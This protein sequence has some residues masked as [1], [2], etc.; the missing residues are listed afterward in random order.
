MFQDITNSS[1]L[2]VSAVSNSMLS[3]TAAGS[4]GEERRRFSGNHVQ[5]SRI[6]FIVSEDVWLVSTVFG[7]VGCTKVYEC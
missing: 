2:K 3:R 7:E 1:K 4:S 5:K 6:A